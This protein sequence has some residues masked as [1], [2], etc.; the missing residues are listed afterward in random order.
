M[1]FKN[2][3]LFLIM[4][5]LIGNIYSYSIYSQDEQNYEYVTS[6]NDSF[7]E[8]NELSDEESFIN[9]ENFHHY[10]VLLSNNILIHKIPSVVS[11]KFS[12]WTPPQN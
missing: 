12:I 1:K 2:I 3:L 4:F 8:N 5:V 9:N 10:F 11:L 6:N 7:E